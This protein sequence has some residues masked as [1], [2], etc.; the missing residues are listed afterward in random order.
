VSKQRDS[1]DNY[2]EGIV[3]RWEAAPYTPKNGHSTK[4]CGVRKK[5]RSRDE[6]DEESDESY[7]AMS[8][9]SNGTPASASPAFL[10]G[11]RKRRRKSRDAVSAPGAAKRPCAKFKLRKV[12]RG[13]GGGDLC[14]ECGWP[15]YPHGVVKCV[16]SRR[17][18][19]SREEEKRGRIKAK[20]AET[21]AARRKQS[22]GRG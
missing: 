20:A 14:S 3:P 2:H 21:R 1:W 16:D 6:D 13:D 18:L 11:V 7:G 22:R 17:R 10:D 15:S 19:E 8:Y 5:K 9:G 4:G 12:L